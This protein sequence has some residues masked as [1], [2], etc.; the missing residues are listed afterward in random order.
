MR[1][2]ILAALTFA[3]V[4][5]LPA[6]Q[7]PGI[8][9]L[10]DRGVQSYHIRRD[11]RAARAIFDTLVSI[12]SIV[13]ARGGQSDE[14][15]RYGHPYLM[16]SAA[17]RKLGDAAGAD[18]DLARAIAITPALGPRSRAIGILRQMDEG[19]A[20]AAQRAVAVDSSRI[21]LPTDGIHLMRRAREKLERGDSAGARIDVDSAKSVDFH[22][23]YSPASLFDR[24]MLRI[25]LT[26]TVGGM[27]DIR[28]A[29]GMG[30]A[31]AQVIAEAGQP[32]SREQIAQVF[33]QR[34]DSVNDMRRR[35]EEAM[36]AVYRKSWLNEAVAWKVTLAAAV[37]S[38]LLITLFGLRLRSIRTAPAAELV[39]EPGERQLWSGM[40]KQGLLF[41]LPLP[42]DP[43]QRALAI[44]WY[45]MAIIVLWY[46]HLWTWVLF[47]MPFFVLFLAAWIMRAQIATGRRRS[48]SYVLTNRRAVVMQGD[49]SRSW[50]AEELRGAQLVEH[51]D[52]TETIQWGSAQGA[53]ESELDR[54]KAEGRAQETVDIAA[55]MH[56]T[57]SGNG[58]FSRMADAKPAYAALQLLH[59]KGPP[60]PAPAPVTATKS[61]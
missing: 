21:R 36:N 18:R 30:S 56:Q 8:A 28:E 16:R 4:A 46:F 33:K 22:N 47:A 42:A 35:S 61:S 45:P 19:P 37:L 49:D 50:A 34:E 10:W 58:A 25:A 14:V 44:S 29:S 54:A 24:G 51:S 26:D 11:Y 27:S 13:R 6:Q 59:T 53:L 12:D 40:P 55:I 38:A 23:P 32:M 52:G 7:S 20:G 41:G 9:A 43:N 60:L 39:M 17:R 31:D 2:A 57:R 5:M 15:F 1:R 48:T 3:D